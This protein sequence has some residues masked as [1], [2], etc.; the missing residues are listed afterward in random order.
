MRHVRLRPY[1]GEDFLQFLMILGGGLI[2]K[3]GPTIQLAGSVFVGT[4]SGFPPGGLRSRNAHDHDMVAAGLRPFPQYTAR[5]YL[6]SLE[7]LTKTHMLFQTA[8]FTK[9]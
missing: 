9:P 3:E 7:E 4:T 8:L 1:S 2:G 5:W 6:S